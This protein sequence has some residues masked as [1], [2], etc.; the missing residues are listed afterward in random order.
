M[1]DFIIILIGFALMAYSAYS[2]NQKAKNKQRAAREDYA[3]PEDQDTGQSGESKDILE[4]F[5]GYE[6]EQGQ[7]QHPF[8]HAEPGYRNREANTA[9]ASHEEHY[10]ASP[11]GYSA[12]NNET[13]PITIKKINQEGEHLRT[14]AESQKSGRYKKRRRTE[15]SQKKQQWFNLRNAVIYSEIINRK[16]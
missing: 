10:A 3:A 6:T 13:E 15:A 1:E 5:F 8:D 11:Q 9:T 2:K 7:E 16:Y 14:S 12:R 4:Q